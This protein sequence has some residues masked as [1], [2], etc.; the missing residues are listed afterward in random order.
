MR[1]LLKGRGRSNTSIGWGD[2]EMGREFEDMISGETRVGKANNLQEK[3]HENEFNV[4]NKCVYICLSH[5]FKLFSV[6]HETIT[7]CE[8]LYH[9]NTHVIVVGVAV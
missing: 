2:T 7:V 1:G 9:H 3:N 4:N 8:S 5:G 6:Y